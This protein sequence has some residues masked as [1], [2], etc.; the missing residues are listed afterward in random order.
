M[1]KAAIVCATLLLASCDN[2][3]NTL[4]VTVANP[5]APRGIGGSAS[6]SVVI[7]PILTI[8][9][10]PFTTL[11]TPQVTLRVGSGSSTLLFDTVTFRLISGTS[12]GGPMVTFQR[13][14]LVDLFGTTSIVGTRAFTFTP[15]F[16]CG[17]GRPTLL[18]A[19]V[20]LVDQSTHNRSMFSVSANVP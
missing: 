15:T 14:G 1:R 9:S 7:Q 12:V 19:D 20:A 17:F 6:T 4:G 18:T 5:L 10:C 16:P 8:A 13:A 2:G 11:F 3:G